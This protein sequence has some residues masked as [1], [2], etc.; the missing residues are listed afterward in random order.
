MLHGNV[1]LNHVVIGEWTATRTG[2][3]KKEFND[4]HCT[5]WYR[6]TDGYLYTHDWHI[7]GMHSGNGAFSLAARVLQEGNAHAKRKPVNTED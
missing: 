1:E 6:G 5:I 4:Y 7:W 2:T 3:T